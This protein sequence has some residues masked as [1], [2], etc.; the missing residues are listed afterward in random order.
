MPSDMEILINDIG[1]LI[2]DP[3]KLLSFIEKY[4]LDTAFSV[5][6]GAYGIYSSYQQ[7][8]ILEQ[9]TI[10]LE[11]VLKQTKALENLI[12]KE[13]DALII[14]SALSDSNSAYQDL[15]GFENIT[16][17]NEKSQKLTVAR[18]KASSAYDLVKHNPRLNNLAYLTTFLVCASNLLWIDNQEFTHF[19]RRG[20]KYINTLL[21]TINY[22][23][24]TIPDLKR[25]I[26]RRF[27]D[28]KTKIEDYPAEYPTGPGRRKVNAY[29]FFDGGIVWVR[30]DYI[31]GAGAT[32]EQY[33]REID[34]KINQHLE[35]L[36]AESQPLIEILSQTQ[37]N[38]EIQL[39]D[40][41]MRYVLNHPPATVP[42]AS[43]DHRSRQI[44][45]RRVGYRELARRHADGTQGHDHIDKSHVDILLHPPL[46]PG[47]R[48]LPHWIPIL[49]EEGYHNFRLHLAGKPEAQ[50]NLEKAFRA[51]Y[52][53]PPT[54]PERNHHTSILA[55]Y[56]YHR[57]VEIMRNPLAV[58][59]TYTTTRNEQKLSSGKNTGIAQKSM[60]SI[61][62][63]SSTLVRRNES[64]PD[65]NQVSDPTTQEVKTLAKL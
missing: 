46:E 42:M 30:K 59:T 31:R 41:M 52:N 14:K 64:V 8:K 48:P 51:Q 44:D 10:L 24:Q 36:Y 12:K 27:G 13:F 35:E 54:G 1:E 61:K 16:N 28:R 50:R 15:V 9:Q 23:A 25:Y 38:Y 26:R 19:P 11:Q 3:L 49:A 62:G 45:L 58:E 20:K 60:F 43:R 5:I 18:S 53:R 22:I 40:A 39:M 34:V 32:H 63:A 17:S 6:S 56:G 2:D 57:M 37:Y 21:N 29:Y 33:Q 65:D 47:E 55:D 4:R 7:T